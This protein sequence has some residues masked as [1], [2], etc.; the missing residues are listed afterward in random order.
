MN[1]NLNPAVFLDR[2]GVLCRTTVCNGKPYAPQHL[3]DFILL[4]NA[5][6]SVKLLK[7]LGFKVI[8][9][10]NQPDIGNGLVSSKVVD[11]MHRKLYAKTKVDDIFMCAHRQDEGCNCRK[12]KAGMLFAAS[13]KHGIDL[14]RSFMVGDRTGDIKAG[15]EVGCRTIFIDRRYKEPRPSK[16]DATVKSLQSAT[17]FIFNAINRKK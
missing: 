16:T 15:Q 13:D 3:K 5:Y 10:T 17:V 14:K 4:P 9:V 12:P 11:D 6:R 1:K 2:D 8:V 7:Q